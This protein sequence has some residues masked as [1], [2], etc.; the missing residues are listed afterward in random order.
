MK[1]LKLW[2]SEYKWQRKCY[3]NGTRYY[4][5]HKLGFFVSPTLGLG[6]VKTFKADIAE[7][8]GDPSIS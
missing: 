4:L 3:L 5:L 7:R 6:G 1:L 8:K 2:Y